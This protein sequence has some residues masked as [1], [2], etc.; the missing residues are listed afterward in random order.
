M[1]YL[2]KITHEQKLENSPLWKYTFLDTQTNQKDY[3]YHHQPISYNPDSIG[4]LS[5][6]SNKFLQ[7]FKKEIDEIVE[8]TQQREILTELEGEARN[9]VDKVFGKLS[10]KQISLSPKKLHEL[11][12]QGLT[13][14]KVGLIYGKSEATI[15]RWIRPTPKPLQKRGR[16]PKFSQEVLKLLTNYNQINNTATQQERANYISQKLGISISQQ[17]ISLLLKKLGITRKKLT[18]HYIQLNEEKAKEF[19]EEIKPLLDTYPF[20]ALDECSFYPN[21]DPRFGY[22]LKGERAVAKIP[23]HKG[24]HYTLL[25]AISNLKENGVV[26]WKL[27]ESKVDYKVFYD[28]LEELKSIGDKKNILLMDNAKIHTAFRKRKEAG[29]PMVEEQMAR[30]NMEVRYITP[31]APMLNPAEYC[32]NLLRQQTEK[33]KP[34]SYK[35][36]KNAIEKVVELLNQKDL[37]EYFRHCVEY[38][39]E[40]EVKIILKDYH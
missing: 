8:R 4:K 27:V 19:N 26:H 13:W 35:E 7:S 28:F 37:P 11:H 25:F 20:I 34:R 32:F 38:F 23:S 39:D 9:N 24:K 17:T 30:K 15:Y 5:I 22:S 14:K 1:D 3:F 31:Y 16:K 40:K 6:S 29:L 33:Q 2:A 18:C 10:K 36:M 21:S 12:A